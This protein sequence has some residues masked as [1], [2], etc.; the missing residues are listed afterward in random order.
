M[1]LNE[2]YQY[3]Q[4]GISPNSD[5]QIFKELDYCFKRYNLKPSMYISYE[6]YSYSGKEDDNF[7]IT[8]DTN[9]L[10]RDYDLNLDKGDYGTSLID[11][12]TYLMEVKCTGGMP[13][14]FT[15]VLTEMKIYPISFSKYGEIYQKNLK[16]QK[17]LKIS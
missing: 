17:L 13:I 15:N 3:L 12:Q 8:F 9:I 1:T 14:W 7:R 10:S 11:N 2:A 5:K 4:N 16:K 6:R